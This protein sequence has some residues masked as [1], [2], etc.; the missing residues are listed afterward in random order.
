[1]LSHYIMICYCLLT[2]IE[3][4]CKIFTN[5]EHNKN[6]GHVNLHVWR[7]LIQI[8]PSVFLYD[9]LAINWQVLIWIHRYYY[10]SYV[11]LL[12]KKDK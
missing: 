2:R 8:F 10:S 5:L 4:F 3:F 1:M 12:K 7:Q 9:I 11:S 6:R